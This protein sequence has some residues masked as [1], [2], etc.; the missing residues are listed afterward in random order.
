MKDEELEMKDMVEGTWDNKQKKMD[1]GQRKNHQWK[2]KG[3][4]AN[5]EGNE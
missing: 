1:K 4:R 5:G 2:D 3:K